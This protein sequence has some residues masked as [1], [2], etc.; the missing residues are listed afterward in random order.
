MRVRTFS[1]TLAIVLAVSSRIDGQEH[2]GVQ[3]DCDSLRNAASADLVAF[4]NEVSPDEKNGDCVTWA[5]KRLGSERFEGSIAALT[6]LL[7]FRRPVTER[8]KQGFYLRPQTIDEIYPAVAA[9][10]M[11]GRESLPA[12][13][14]VMKA[15]SSS[16]KAQENAVFVW[17]EIFRY[18][19]EHPKGVALLKQEESNARDETTR[20]RLKS[21]VQRALTHCNLPEAAACKE[22][23]ETGTAPSSKPTASNR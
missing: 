7:D 18:S 6:R 22:A 12:V 15:D 11:I 19:D 17:M 2:Y 5:I 21:A 13:M 4:L 16:A 1:L 3:N 20:R 14:R 8:E 23:A 10:E 9:L